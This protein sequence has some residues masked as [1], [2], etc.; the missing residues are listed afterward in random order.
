M[1]K[2]NFKIDLP[3]G[4]QLKIYLGLALALLFFFFI[5]FLIF[6]VGE[7]T[8]LLING[9]FLVFIFL[10]PLLYVSTT[11]SESNEIAVTEKDHPRL[12]NLIREVSEELN[13]KMPKK[14]LLLPSTQI[15]VKGFFSKTLIIGIATLGSLSQ[16]EFKAILAHEFGHFY[17]KDTIIGGILWNVNRSLE[18]TAGFGKQWFNVMPLAELALIGLIVALFF[19]LYSFLFGL[20][21]ALYS[22]Q[23]EYRADFIAST[24]AG[25]NNFSM[26]LTA[27]SAFSEYFN[28]VSYSQV[29]KLSEQQKAFVNVYEAISDAYMR[30]DQDK[31]V[32]HVIEDERKHFFQT[33]PSLKQRLKA[34][35]GLPSKNTKKDEP[36]INLLNDYEKLEQEMTQ[37]LT[38]LIHKSHQQAVINAL[39]EDAKKRQGRCRYC[40]TQF[41]TLGEL[42]QHEAK[43]EKRQ[44]PS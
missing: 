19:K 26:G 36:A 41:K 43:C 14:V 3:K 35:S 1:G 16:D 28:V 32:R 11:E 13:I 31:I 10:L 29:L 37:V 8:K 2:Q 22:R 20:I 18:A 4:L 12:F 42:L 30:E 9:Y 40:R 7:Q 39:L 25:P 23:V 38:K 6:L 15:A 34:V 21:T 27:Y 44:T 33:H 17:G 24:V 5:Y